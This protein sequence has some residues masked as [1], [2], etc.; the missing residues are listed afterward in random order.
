[1]QINVKHWP[2][3]QLVGGF[4]VYRN[5]ASRCIWQSLRRI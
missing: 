5:R 1:M 2:A 3:L 4:V